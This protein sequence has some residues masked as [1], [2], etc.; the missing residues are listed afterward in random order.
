VSAFG[1][2]VAPVHPS[3]VALQPMRVMLRSPSRTWDLMDRGGAMP[4][5]I[6]F[7]LRKEDPLSEIEDAVRHALISIPAFEINE[8]EVPGSRL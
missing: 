6:A 3:H 2:S 7:N 5:V 4:L 1:E 8:Y